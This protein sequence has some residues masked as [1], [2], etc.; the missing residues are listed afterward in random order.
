MDATPT[1]EA[2]NVVLAECIP[3]AVEVEDV[4]VNTATESSPNASIDTAMQTWRFSLTVGNLIDAKDLA[5]NWYQVS[6]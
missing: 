6:S 4:A 5:N 2:E 1:L 3:T